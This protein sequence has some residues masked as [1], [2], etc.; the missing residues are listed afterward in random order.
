[1][2]AGPARFCA[3]CMVGL[4][5]RRMDAHRAEWFV[6]GLQQ[7]QSR[8]R[9]RGRDCVCP[10]PDQFFRASGVS[11][12]L[13]CIPVHERGD[14]RLNNTNR[15]FYDRLLNHK[16]ALH[17]L[18]A[19]R[20]MLARISSERPSHPLVASPHQVYAPACSLADLPRRALVG[21]LLGPPYAYQGAAKARGRDAGGAAQGAFAA[22]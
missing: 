1:M 10:A 11:A 3:S 22:T 18:F 21:H 16:R 12:A 8:P 9:C 5:Q 17:G 7:T 20:A 13:L 4:G 15:S 14:F 19:M 2:S 6:D